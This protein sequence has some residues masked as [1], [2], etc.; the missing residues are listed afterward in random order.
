VQLLFITINC[1]DGEGIDQVNARSALFKMW[2]AAWFFDMVLTAT[3]KK[4][5]SD[6]FMFT[7]KQAK[8]LRGSKRIFE[9]GSKMIEACTN[10]EAG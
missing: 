1:L 8:W 5:C 9:A 6:S 4:R 10:V 7:R 2:N 3:E